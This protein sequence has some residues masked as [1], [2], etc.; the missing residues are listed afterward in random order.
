[1]TL[2]APTRTGSAPIGGDG[3]EQDSGETIA[4][5]ACSRAN[6]CPVRHLGCSPDGVLRL[7][8]TVARGPREHRRLDLELKEVLFLTWR[9]RGQSGTLVGELPCQ[10]VPSLEMRNVAGH[11]AQVEGILVV[12]EGKRVHRVATV[13][14]EI[15][16][17]GR[18]DDECVQ[19]GFGEQRTHRVQPWAAVV[20]HCAQEGQADTE[21]VEQAG[22]LAGKF[23]LLGFE[24]AP[25]DHVDR[26]WQIQ[27]GL[28]TPVKRP[29]GYGP[30][31]GT[32]TAAA[33]VAAVAALVLAH[34]PQ[35]A[36]TPGSASAVRDA[37]R[38]DGLFQVLVSACR[39][40]PELGPF[41]AGA[42]LPDAAVAVGVAPWGDF[43]RLH[44]YFH[45]HAALAGRGPV[46]EDGTLAPLDAAM[47]SAGLISGKGLASA[48]RAY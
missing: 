28:S 43:A 5:A 10:P 14:V 35:F 47:R 48:R 36:A 46:E 24:V 39:P 37:R 1:L 42:G 19:P 20:P 21:V 2:H 40:L 15:P 11:P 45:S 26:A 12:F 41:R 32:A 17:L 13:A 23:G 3:V 7:R 31:S 16:L 38:V 8:I 33:H 44:A 34:H 22:S 9:W 4:Q 27:I 18:R 25:R 29:V 30:L 6:R